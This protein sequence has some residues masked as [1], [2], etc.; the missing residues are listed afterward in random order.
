MK[1]LILGNSGFLGKKISDHLYKKKVDIY[2]SQREEFIIK[3]NNLEISESLRKKLLCVDICIN[4]IAIT[5]FQVCEISPISKLINVKMVK[6]IRNLL[7]QNAYLI[8]F[9]SD[10]FYSSEDNFSSE[11][12]KLSFV[13]AYARQK[14][15]SEKQLRDSNSI[16]LRTSFIGINHKKKGMINYFLDCHENKKKLIGWKNVNTS[17]VHVFH[18]CELIFSLIKERPIGLFNFGTERPYSKGELLNFLFS[19]LPTEIPSIELI[20]YKDEEFN[21]NKNTGMDSSKILNKLNIKLPNFNSVSSNCIK[22]IKF[23]K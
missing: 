22:E 8:H 16:I 5:D 11:N 2:F 19:K 20:D 9:S 14:Y 4:C 23:G 15:E 18:I 6:K 10:V 17:S 1:V 21:R 13:N 12:H 3:N 7:K